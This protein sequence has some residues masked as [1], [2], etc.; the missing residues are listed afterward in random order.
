M[1]EN[2]TKVCHVQPFLKSSGISMSH[3][4]NSWKRSRK[5]ILDIYL[6]VYMCTQ[7]CVWGCHC[8]P[9]IGHTV[10]MWS[11][12]SLIPWLETVHVCVALYHCNHEESFLGQSFQASHRD[13][14]ALPLR[15][16]QIKTAQSKVITSKVASKHKGQQATGLQNKKGQT[17]FSQAPV[18]TQKERL[19]QNIEERPEALP[20]ENPTLPRRNPH[21]TL[22]Y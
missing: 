3:T 6:H 12:H 22:L 20:R 11:C 17:T 13:S 21:S 7:V 1:L 14:P 8:D 5:D 19:G 10:C 15:S 2:G 9:M 4:V 16:K 18:C